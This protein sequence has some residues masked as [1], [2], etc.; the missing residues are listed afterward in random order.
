MV[1]ELD[2][3]LRTKYDVNF[4][5]VGDSGSA[6]LEVPIPE[7]ARAVLRSGPIRVLDRETKAFLGSVYA[8]AYYIFS[9]DEP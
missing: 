1:K 2:A 4:I 3:V 6:E 5:R 9:T 7:K 8:P